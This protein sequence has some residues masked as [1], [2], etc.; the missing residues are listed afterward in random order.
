MT[1][2]STTTRWS[3]VQVAQGDT[4]EARVA[5]SELCAIYYAPVHSFVRGWCRD[6]DDADDLAQEFFARLLARND[7]ANADQGRGR[8]RSFLL[9]A[10][11]HFLCDARDRDLAEKRGGDVVR[12]S[13]DAALSTHG[14]APGLEPH[15]ER[16]LPPDVMFDRQWVCVLLERTLEALRKEMRGEGKGEVFDALKGAL[17]GAS[18][19]GDLAKAAAQ[20][21]LSETAIRVLLHRLRR[22]FRERLR[23]ELA[24]TLADGV[25]VDAEMR[26][27][28]EAVTES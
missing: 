7:L 1:P 24:Q 5:L 2:S 26:L 20:L 8:F 25:D 10:V 6:G 13:L 23:M 4:P 16:A 17:A 22:R 12:V 28:F 9:G 3:L 21:N 11:K 27:L 18:A 14:G 15:D 19:H